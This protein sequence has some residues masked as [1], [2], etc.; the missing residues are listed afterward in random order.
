[1][2]NHKDDYHLEDDL[3]VDDQNDLKEPKMYKVIL[4][5]DDYTSMDFVVSIL[6]TVFKKTF[7]DANRLMLAVHQQGQ[8]VCGIYTRQIAET[9]VLL[10][11]D[12]ATAE[13]FPLRCV[14]EED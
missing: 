4:L 12:R 8:A 5:N 9:K 1:M 2:T 13:G 14:M 7:E 6:Q 3:L 10:V 11:H